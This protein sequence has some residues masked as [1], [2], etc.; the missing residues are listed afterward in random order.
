MKVLIRY[1]TILYDD[2]TVISRK[3]WEAWKHGGGEAWNLEH[4][5]NRT[6]EPG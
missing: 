1:D 3:A 4:W 6:I 5:N 2:D